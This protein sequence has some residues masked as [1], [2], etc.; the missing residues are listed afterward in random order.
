METKRFLKSEFEFLHQSISQEISEVLSKQ[1]LWQFMFM[2]LHS[3]FMPEKFEIHITVKYWIV[4]R[5]TAHS[6][7]VHEFLKNI[8]MV[9]EKEYKTDP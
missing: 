8:A 3:Q 4:D 5:S 7:A 6:F 1:E 2:I 9:Q